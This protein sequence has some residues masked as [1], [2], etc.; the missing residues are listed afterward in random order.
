[1]P[2]SIALMVVSTFVLPFSVVAVEL[3]TGKATPNSAVAGAFVSTIWLV[4]SL[5]F[6]AVA[7]ARPALRAG[8]R[9]RD[10]VIAVVAL[11]LQLASLL[12]GLL[13]V[14]LALQPLLTSVLHS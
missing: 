11:G 1:M 13:S 4:L 5:A 10:E 2:L 3:H 7:V 14:V 12:A 8:Q 9:R 6:G